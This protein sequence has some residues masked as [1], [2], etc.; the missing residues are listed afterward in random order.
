MLNSQCILSSS[1]L[2]HHWATIHL[3]QSGLVAMADVVSSERRSWNMS[4]IRSR[5]T[6]PELA[7]RSLLHRAG[8]RFS[9]HGPLNRSLP[10]RPD[11]V[12]PRQR[13]VVF[14][15]G[16]FW[17]RH[18]GCSFAYTPKSNIPFWEEK[19]R[20]NVVRDSDVSQ[21]LAEGG[22]RQFVIWQCEIKANPDE[23]LSRFRSFM[24]AEGKV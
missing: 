10:G 9:V 22:W 3:N 11:V 2:W 18:R 7:V 19:F 1:R 15:H 24:Q 20:R 16:C 4:R 12:F 13:V 8:Y 23:V 17:H 5:D 14:V 6:K 21:I